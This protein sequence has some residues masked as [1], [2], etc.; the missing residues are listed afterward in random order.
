MRGIVADSLGLSGSSRKT[1]YTV[2]HSSLNSFPMRRVSRVD[3]VILVK[4]QRS[5]LL[6]SSL[7]SILK[8]TSVTFVIFEGS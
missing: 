2:S 3:D 5:M 1:S 8:S 4:L 7:M 6:I